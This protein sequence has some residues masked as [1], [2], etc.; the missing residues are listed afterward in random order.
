MAYGTP[1]YDYGVATSNLTARKGQEDVARDFGRFMGQERFRRS[2][3][4]NQ[5]TFKRQ[6]PNVAS[7]FNQRGLH[8][9]G[10][11]QQGQRQFVQDYNQ[12]QE[13]SNF[14]RAAEVAGIDLQQTQSDANYQ[15]ALLDLYELYQGQR[16]AG[17]DPFAAVR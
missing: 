6:F 17:F 4:D 13:R 11:R 5:Q 16:A 8:N 15:K 7:H 14:D 1:S 2:T 10:L 12:T 9:S 3:Q